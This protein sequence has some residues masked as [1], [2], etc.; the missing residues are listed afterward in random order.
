MLV[1]SFNKIF[2]SGQK[3]DLQ[4]RKQS[5]SRHVKGGDFL[6]TFFGINS[7]NLCPI[8]FSSYWLIDFGICDQLWLIIDTGLQHIVYQSTFK[9]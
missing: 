2:F 4:W 7:P 5:G 6:A 3:D 9:S 8:R 1:L